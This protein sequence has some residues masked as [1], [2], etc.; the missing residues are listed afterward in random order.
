MVYPD[1][2]IIM[3]DLKNEKEIEKIKLN[4]PSCGNIEINKNEILEEITL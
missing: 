3:L 1:N 2:N 4:T